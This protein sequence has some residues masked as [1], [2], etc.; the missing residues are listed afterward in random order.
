MCQ[1]A[2]QVSAEKLEQTRPDENKRITL[3]PESEQLARM[4]EPSIANE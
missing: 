3:L 1:N 2:W 4:Q